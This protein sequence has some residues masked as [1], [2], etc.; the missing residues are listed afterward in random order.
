VIDELIQPAPGDRTFFAR[1][2]SKTGPDGFL[3]SDNVHRL[4]LEAGQRGMTAIPPDAD[5]LGRDSIKVDLEALMLHMR[6]LER[7][8]EW[9]PGA[10]AEIDTRLCARCLTCLRACPYGAVFFSNRMEI[11][12]DACFGCGI[13]EAACPAGA[14]HLSERK[15]ILKDEPP[16]LTEKDMPPKPGAVVVYGCRRSAERAME[17]CRHMGRTLPKELHFI[18][19]DCGGRISSRMLLEP[20]LNDAAGVLVLTCHSGNCHAEEGN[21][22][23]RSRTQ[24]VRKTLEEIG[25]E[26]DRIGFYTLAANTGVAFGRVIGEF[27]EKLG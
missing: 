16:S 14:I 24:E 13:C 8:K 17:L 9:V 26:N 22:V 19:V 10:V 6:A 4:G 21:H 27:V 7:L 11:S 12:P 15:D 1:L 23:A 20:F 5:P 2:R 25:I 3:P 18:P